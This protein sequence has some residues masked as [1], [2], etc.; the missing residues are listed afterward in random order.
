M[1]WFSLL[2]PFL[3]SCVFLI[4]YRKQD[5]RL[6]PYD[7]DIIKEYLFILFVPT[8]FVALI[9]G[10][11]YGAMINSNT[12]DIE[13]LSYHYTKI[14]HEDEWNERVWVTKTRTVTDSNGKTHTETYRVRETRYHSDE[15]YGYLNDGSKRWLH[16]DEYNS[17]KKLWNVPEQFIDMHRDYYTIDGDAQEYE[18]DNNRNTV[19]PY[20]KEHHYCNKVIGTESAF[21]FNEITKEEAKE[22]GLYDYPEIKDNEQNPIIGFKRFVK[23]ND[24]KQIQQLNAV[25]GLKKQISFYLLIYPNTSAAIA[26]D[27]RSYWQGG[28]K[29]EFVICVGVDSLTNQVQWSQCFSWLDDVTME[30]Q[31]RD[32]INNQDKLD[33]INFGNWLESHLHL[34]KRK[35]FKDF[36]YLNI[37]LT[38]SQEI[39][40][41]WT[42]VIM[43]ILIGILGIFIVININK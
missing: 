37:S 27:Q 35:E 23:P 40:I 32:Y 7:S 18:W 21:K 5:D 6:F 25:Y 36:N 8:L 12:D 31:C 43:S 9:V 29:N 22:L 26:E 17:I 1:I 28:N 4:W 19:K 34:W 39:S 15:W 2:I 41:L 24:I 42:V 11:M 13:Y 10:I 14:R 20:V 3:I 16:S 38:D 33:I 30:V